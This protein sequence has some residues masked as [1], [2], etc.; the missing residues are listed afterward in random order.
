MN[1]TLVPV[2]HVDQIWSAVGEGLHDACLKTGGD[3]TGSDLW[4]ECRAGSAFLIVAHDD[5]DIIAASVWRPETWATGHKFRCLSLYGRDI[6]NWFNDMENSVKAVARSCGAT[7]LVT[8][9]RDGWQR[10]RPKA[11]KLR[12]LYEEEI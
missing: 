2:Q 9:G 6:K 12:I 8:E 3:C 11:R 10:L 1:I 7:A 4:Q 5:A